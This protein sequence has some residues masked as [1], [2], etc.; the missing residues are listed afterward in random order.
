MVTL[1]MEIFISQIM[2]G[3]KK[4]LGGVQI[5]V[6][7]EQ[8]EEVMLNLERLKDLKKILLLN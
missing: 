8:Q 3:V 1:F 6:L 4:F 7:L 5:L 2:L